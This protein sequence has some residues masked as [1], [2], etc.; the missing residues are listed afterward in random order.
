MTINFVD[1]VDNA[2]L[3]RMMRWADSIPGLAQTF[4]L[5]HA[6]YG[7][8]CTGGY[9]ADW[10]QIDEDG[11]FL[12]A[13][14]LAYWWWFDDLIDEN[15]KLASSIVA[16]A[17]LERVL[18]AVPL[19]HV[20]N[21]EPP[22][23]GFLRALSDAY[24]TRGARHEDHAWWVQA[25]LGTL[26][27][28]RDEETAT[29]SRSSVSYAEQLEAGMWSATLLNVTA[30]ASALMGLGFGA[31]AHPEPTTAERLLCLVARLENDEHSLDKELAEG[32]ASNVAV[33][34]SRSFAP[35]AIPSFVV[36]QRAGYQRLLEQSL[37]VLGAAH[38][39]TL[40][41]RG[42]LRTHRVFY[43]QRPQRYDVA[44]T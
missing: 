20:T 34:L 17:E 29:R 19:P 1:Q 37:A 13:L 10:A 40:L 22:E 8:Y 39:F 5:D 3:E 41:A 43:A 18:G 2:V 21:V 38:P 11:R 14:N 35:E 32:C 42:I 12:F 44:P 16:W 25:T 31:R 33:V 36:A 30:S 24:A 27:G 4:R 23:V 6:S 9:L 26:L 28:F 15:I 7:L